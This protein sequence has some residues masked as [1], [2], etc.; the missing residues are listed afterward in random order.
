MIL[1]IILALTGQVMLMT[2][3]QLWK[4]G[5]FHGRPC[6]LSTTQQHDEG[7]SAFVV[8]NLESRPQSKCVSTSL[9]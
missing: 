5:C 7:P 9:Y 6:C 8:P 2:K 4:R 3:N 1:N